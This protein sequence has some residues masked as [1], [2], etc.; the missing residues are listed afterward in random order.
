MNRFPPVIAVVDDEDS[1]R[2]AL[3]RL[4]QSA[5]FQVAVF[6]S[7]EEFLRSL[8]ETTPNC[9]VLDLHMPDVN[10]F[11]VQEALGRDHPGLPIVI[12]TGYDTAETKARVLQ[13]GAVA[14]LGKPVD[15]MVL[16]ASIS[17]ALSGSIDAVGE[18]RSPAK[19]PPQGK[20]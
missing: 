19:M 15:A 4:L 1:V 11:D 3:L 20:P 8:N 12:I 7:G 14:Y 6:A 9:V 13:H 2:R 18:S 17:H 10:G 5:G 16:L